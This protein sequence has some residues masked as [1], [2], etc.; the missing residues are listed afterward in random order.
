MSYKTLTLSV[1]IIKKYLFYIRLFFHFLD[2][3]NILRP[4]NIRQLL[5]YQ[6]YC[7]YHIFRNVSLKHLDTIPL[8]DV[9]ERLIHAAIQ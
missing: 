7:A 5:K 3:T 1:S 8:I 9:Y 2:F 6:Q 4:H